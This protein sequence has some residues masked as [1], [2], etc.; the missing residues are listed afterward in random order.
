MKAKIIYS[1]LPGLILSAGVTASA[2]LAERIEIMLAGR[3]WLEPLVLAILLGSVVRTGL[4]P[5][6]S[7]DR[8]IRFASK[9]LLEAAVVLMGATIGFDAIFSA[10]GTLLGG[11]VATV[12]ATIAISFC[13]GRALGLP[14]RMALLVAC[15]NAICGNSAIAA[16]APVID[17]ESDD[18]AT[19][20]AF[21]AVLGIAVVL[22]LP[23]V[24]SG[25]HLSPQAGGALAGLTVY[26]VPQVLAAAAPMGPAAVQLGTLVKL[27]RVLMLGPVLALLSLLKRRT[28]AE[29]TN[30]GRGHMLHDILPGFILGFFALATLRTCA[31]LPDA[32]V[33]RAH[34]AS[35]LLTVIAMAGLGLEVDV[36]QVTAAG[37]R[38]SFTVIASLAVLGCISL[39][40]IHAGGL[41]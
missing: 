41:A 33:A 16:V 28:E 35:D 14:H 17:A 39:Y 27:V 20:I 3:A 22:L 7:C 2:F 12:F 40:V 18:V 19:A 24:A 38:V 25:L 1:T 6:A 29:L 11:I 10:G 34:G 37:A 30:G 23:V 26:A 15:G 36:R 4:K 5:P 31:V 21:T 8:G 9:S 32:F 13:L